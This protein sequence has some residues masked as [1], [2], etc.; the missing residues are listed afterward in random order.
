MAAAARDET[1][2]GSTGEGIGA[3]QVE[4]AGLAQLLPEGLQTLCV[5]RSK[6]EALEMSIDGLEV[7]CVS[8]ALRTR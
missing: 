1:P 7:A 3:R 4:L 2:L 5:K 6:L 8:R